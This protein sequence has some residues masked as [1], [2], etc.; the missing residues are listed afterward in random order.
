MSARERTVPLTG[1]LEI[2]A[3]RALSPAMVLAGRFELRRQLG[4]GGAARVF[5]AYDRAARTTVALKVLRE[6]CARDRGWARRL[7]R[8][9]LI[10][11]RVVHPNVCRTYELGFDADRLFITM[12]LASRGTLREA[13]DGALRWGGARVVVDVQWSTRLAIA[14]AICSGVAALHE[15]GV[16]HGDLTPRN[17]LRARGGRW[18]V[19]D[20]GLALPSGESTTFFGGTPRYMPPELAYGLRPGRRG[21]V[22]QLGVVLHELLLG[23]HPRWTLRAGRPSLRSAIARGDASARHVRAIV[24][25][26]LDQDP[27]RRPADASAVADLLKSTQGPLDIHLAGCVA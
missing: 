16:T 11:R 12:E 14:K 6:D 1:S 22:W 18:F 10:A 2:R 5:A 7:T 15:A 3:A 24:A 26:C 19:S 20:F 4:Q 23:G 8:E 13:L 9:F 27:A 17:I 21:D 25:R